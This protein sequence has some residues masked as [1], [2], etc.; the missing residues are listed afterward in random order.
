MRSR[1][2][3]VT[4]LFSID[5]SNTFNHRA[6]IPTQLMLYRS[7]AKEAV[8]DAPV[9]PLYL[10]NV[11]KVYISIMGTIVYLLWTAPGILWT[12]S[13]AAYACTVLTTWALYAVTVRS[14]PGYI[15]VP[16]S[17]AESS[18]D[19]P[20][21]LTDSFL[22]VRTLYCKQRERYVA[23]YDHFCSTMDTPIGERNLFR[24]YWL[25]LF[26]TVISAWSLLYARQSN[27]RQ[28]Q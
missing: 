27:S 17:D 9:T 15:E 6:V 14:D 3:T 21:P 22:P 26:T 16:T 24:F 7:E 28:V 2:A 10:R 1:T 8:V 23:T 20:H 4:A 19:E 25:V 13:S 5:H 12:T 18:S 11:I